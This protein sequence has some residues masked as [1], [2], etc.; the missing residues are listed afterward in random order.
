MCH[1]GSWSDSVQIDSCRSRY[2]FAY[3][4]FLK[5]GHPGRQLNLVFVLLCLVHRFKRLITVLYLIW[6]WFIA[7]TLKQSSSLL[8]LLWLREHPS[9]LGTS[10]RV[11]TAVNLEGTRNIVH[12][13][14]SKDRPTSRDI[15]CSV[16]DHCNKLHITMKQVMWIFWFPSEYK[17]YV[18]TKWKFLRRVRL[19]V[20]PW[21]IQSMGFSRP[22]Y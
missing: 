17:S 12:C 22:E 4:T 7:L 6:R 15:S 20:T 8:H 2:I 18:H 14:K 1:R 11:W 10:L 19:F 13:I 16:P 21:T 5:K 9:G 3:F